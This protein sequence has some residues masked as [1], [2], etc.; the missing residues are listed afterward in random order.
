MPVVRD[1]DRDPMGVTT[2][3][4]LS[5]SQRQ[6]SARPC[7]ATGPVIGYYMRARGKRKLMRGL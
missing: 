4:K 6:L 1:L 2:E 5:K 3:R 7:A